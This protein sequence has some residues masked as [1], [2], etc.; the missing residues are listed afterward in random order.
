MCGDSGERRRP[1]SCARDVRGV[2][3]AEVNWQRRKR[4]REEREI[5]KNQR[6]II[7]AIPGQ[8]GPMAPPEHCPGSVGGGACIVAAQCSG[9]QGLSAVV[10]LRTK[11]AP[12]HPVFTLRHPPAGA[13]PTSPA[14][15]SFFWRS[16]FVCRCTAFAVALCLPSDC[17]SQPGSTDTHVTPAPHYQLFSV[18][19]QSLCWLCMSLRL[20]RRAHRPSA[21][22]AGDSRSHL[23]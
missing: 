17:V 21:R 4:G 23:P 14:A 16:D 11:P 20:S 19:V 12:A 3:R 10:P 1:C 9:S 7:F 2:R 22:C 18:A 5:D 13:L 8:T 6:V 15:L